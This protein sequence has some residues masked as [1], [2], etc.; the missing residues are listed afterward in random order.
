MQTS[1]WDSQNAKQKTQNIA[2]F[3]DSLH[4]YYEAVAD[5]VLN[6]LPGQVFLELYSQQDSYQILQSQ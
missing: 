1:R 2:A 4:P 3:E 6:L 5:L